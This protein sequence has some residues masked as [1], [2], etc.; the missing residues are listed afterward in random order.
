MSSIRLIAPT[1]GFG[2]KLLQKELAANAGKNVLVSP[3]SVSVA[4]AMAMN[5][6]RGKT[7]K[8]IASGLQLPDFGSLAATN[9]S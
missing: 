5:G 8:L 6:A 7:R 9:L 2:V 1:A 3:L 4:M